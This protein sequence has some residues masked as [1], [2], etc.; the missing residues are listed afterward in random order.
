[1]LFQLYYAYHFVSTLRGGSDIFFLIL[2]FEQLYVYC[3]DMI[4]TSQRTCIQVLSYLLMTLIES[5]D[6]VVYQG[7]K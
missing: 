1:M 6:N 3:N 2:F 5:Q 4:S 7:L